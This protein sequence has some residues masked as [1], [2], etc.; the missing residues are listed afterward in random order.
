MIR[1]RDTLEKKKKYETKSRS[2]LEEEF[3]KVGV[4]LVYDMEEKNE[5]LEEEG[6]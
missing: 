6:E 4:K 1:T 3:I 2:Y 5:G